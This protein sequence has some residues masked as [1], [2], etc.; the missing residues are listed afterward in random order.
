VNATVG[1]A[2]AMIDSLTARIGADWRS[3][4][5]ERVFVVNDHGERIE[6]PERQ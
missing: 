6:R 1:Q 3:V 5:C 2:F 4:R